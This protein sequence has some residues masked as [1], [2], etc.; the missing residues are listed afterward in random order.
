[1]S[2]DRGVRAQWW[3]ARFLRPWWRD[4]TSTG[5]GRHG[6]DIENT[7]GVHWEAKTADEFKP[8]AFVR[9]AQKTCPPG[10]LPVVVY[11]PRRVGEEGTADTLAIVPL[12]LFM[13][14]LEDAGYTS[15]TPIRD[16]MSSEE[17]AENPGAGVRWFLNRQRRYER[18][19]ADSTVW[20][21][22]RTGKQRREQP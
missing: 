6:A 5:S 15:E 22:G 2:H 9:Q 3:L 21:D 18:I 20:P 7:P 12:G 14:V 19:V 10:V 17:L 1:M 11:W 13:G 16:A 8:L 4:A